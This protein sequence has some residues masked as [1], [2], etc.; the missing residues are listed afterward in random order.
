M[1]TRYLCVD[2]NPPLNTVQ[3]MVF[4]VLVLHE[5]TDMF[6]SGYSYELSPGNNDPTEV[7]MLVLFRITVSNQLRWLEVAKED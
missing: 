3:L 1:C 2:S 7:I 6:P 4:E 5:N